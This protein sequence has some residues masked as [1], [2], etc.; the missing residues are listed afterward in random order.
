MLRQ[1][2]RRF[3]D[4]RATVVD[5]TDKEVINLFQ[6][7]LYHHHTFEDFDHR[8]SSSITRLKDMITSWADEEDKANAKYDSIHGK[9]KNN[10]GDNNNNK[11]QGGCNN[12]YYLGPNHKRKPDNTVVAIQH[13]AK[14]SSRKTS[15]GFRDL[16][17]EKCP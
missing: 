9:S 1:Y 4:K 6:D 14:D 12:K 2:M 16:L 10:T 15:S 7:G 5:V 17:K 3:F 11:D 13:P 8:R